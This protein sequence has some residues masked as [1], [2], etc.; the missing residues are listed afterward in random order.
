MKTREKFIVVLIFKLINFFIS[1]HK[2]RAKILNKIFSNFTFSDNISIRKNVTFYGKGN[3]IIGNDTFIN[4]ECF[5][6]FSSELIIGNYVA[7]GMRTMILSS[8]HYIEKK[9]CGK[10]KKSLQKLR[11][12]CGL[13]QE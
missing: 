3:L 5:L 13:V 10:I 1:D 7:I 12:M 11:I 2:F 4:E 9:R 8:T 6:D